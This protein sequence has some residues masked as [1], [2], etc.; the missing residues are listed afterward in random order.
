MPT[1]RQTYPVEFRGGLITNMSPLQQGI[2]AA[3]SARVLKNFEPS[4][5]GGYR[6][7]QGYTKYNSSIIPPYGDPVVNGA[8]QSGGTLNIANVRTTPVV[9]D[10]FK[11]THATAQVN[12]T[13]TAVVNGTVSSSTNIAVDGNVGTIVV[14]MTVAINGVDAG[15]TVTTVTDQNNIVVSSAQSIADDA[16]LTFNAPDSDNTTHIVDTVV[17]TIKAGMDVSGT[18]IP[19][20]VTV[21]SIS[22]STVTLSTGLDLAEDLELT[23]SDIYTISSGGVSYNAS[24]RTAAL[25]FT[26]TIHADNSPANGDAVEFTSTASNYLMLGCGVFLDRVIVAK[27]DDLFKVSSSDI[28]QINVPSYGTVLVNGAS[29]SGSSLVVDGLTSAPQQHDIFKIAAAGPT[30]KVNGATSSTTTLVVDNNNG[31]IVA[32]MTVT[33]TGI[34][35]GTTVSSLSD[36]QNLVISSAQSIADDVDLTFSSTTDKIYRVTADATVSSGGA[37]LAISPALDSSP[38]DNAAITFLSTSRESAGK[39]RFARY[40]YTGTEK[41][42]I[43]DGTNVPAL[44]DN[45]TFTALNDAPTD[46]NGASFVVNFKNQL[47]FG[48]SNLLTFTAPY[49][50]NDFTAANGSGTIS[51]GTTITGLVVFRQQLIIFT[52]T[53]IMQLVGNTIADFNLQPITLDI[54]CVD[55][56]TIQEVGGDVMFLGPDGLRLLSGTDRI[57][58]FGLGNVSKT[59][60]KEVTSFISTNTSFASVVVRGKSQ[61]R[62]LGYNNNITQENAQ[63]ILGTQFAGQGGEGMAWAETRGIRAYVADSR[64]YQNTETIVFG[65]DD[66]YLYQMEDGNNFDGANI[67]T[68]FATPYMPINDPRVRK[69]FYKAY[70]Y[71]DPQGSVSFDMSLKLDFDQKD[72]I[73]PT[74]IDFAN[75]TGQVAFYGQASYGSTEVYSTKL[76]TLFETQL[77]GSGFTGS[78]QFES[79]STDPPFSLD[80]ITIE[81]GTNTRR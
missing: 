76:L 35:D 17:G 8:S 45:T 41:I 65:N 60:Q 69:T 51:L 18:G 16:T 80:A 43:V 49:T 52:E 75:S 28:T 21:S 24:E 22:G 50:D 31:T 30:A 78:I 46:V 19:T 57:G 73:Q 55:T 4:I 10:T 63:G 59:I 23:F 81:F 62:I 5:E 77:I 15:I 32:G 79:D 66:G 13:A 72:S 3:G 44:Y 33:G 36:Q 25:T 48:K 42:A 38:A 54:G 37:T 53:S 34:A 61:Y 71:T 9:G 68:T 56:D 2:N 74:E 39:T 20:G 40:N 12:N 70:L 26:P 64:F 47:F 29:Q 58:D 67:Q 14:G 6:R 11:L 7:I 1:T 27:N